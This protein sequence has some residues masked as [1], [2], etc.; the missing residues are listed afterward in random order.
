[1]SLTVYLPIWAMLPWTA[2]LFSS[3]VPA[4]RLLDA[5]LGTPWRTTS[6]AYRPLLS[7]IRRPPGLGPNVSTL[8]PSG[9][10]VIAATNDQVPPSCSLRHFCWRTAPPF[11]TASPNT[12]MAEALKTLRRFMV[13]LP[14]FECLSAPARLL[15]RRDWACHQHR[16]AGSR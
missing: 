6:E 7:K 8:L 11:I 10:V 16:L 13:V 14:G 9:R 15:M 2:A 1:A 4:S 12:A 5:N 3:A